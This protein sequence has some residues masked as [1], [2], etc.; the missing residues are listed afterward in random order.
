MNAWWMNRTRHIIDNHLLHISGGY[1]ISKKC[2]LIPL[3]IIVRGYITGNT[4][5]SLW[6]HYNKH[7]NVMEEL[8]V[9]N[10]VV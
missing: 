7:F 10:I 1:L 9:L 3:E 6:T 8:M 5:T 2:N 4:S